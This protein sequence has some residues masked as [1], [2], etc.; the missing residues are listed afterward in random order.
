MQLELGD[1]PIERLTEILREAEHAHAVYQRG[2]GHAD[3][4]WATWYARHIIHRLSE[5]ESARSE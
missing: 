1:R 4:A 2:L 3:P 5:D